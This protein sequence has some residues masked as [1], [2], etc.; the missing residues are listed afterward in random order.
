MCIKK[1]STLCIT[2]L[3]FYH[4]LWSQ[5]ITSLKKNVWKLPKDS[6]V[7]TLNK[8]K[9]IT[10]DLEVFSIK[11][12]W[13]ELLEEAGKKGN[14]LLKIEIYKV[15]EETLNHGKH[16]NDM[17]RVSGERLVYAE[18]MGLLDEAGLANLKL[19]GQYRWLNKSDKALSFLLKAK[20][21]F[22]KTDN[23]ENLYRVYSELGSFYC[24]I[25]PAKAREYINKALAII[26][27]TTISRA[28]S[29]SVI[30]NINTKALTY[31]AEN[32]E[33]EALK[34][35]EEAL[36]FAIT[37]KDS[38]WEGIISGNMAMI[39]MKQKDYDKALAFM[40]KDL[41]LSR[42]E[43]NS[44]NTHDAIGE[45]YI[46]KGEYDI[47]LKHLDSA[48]YLA[49]KL[50]SIKVLYGVHNGYHK[51][52]KKLNNIDKAYFHLGEMFA[53]RDS[54]YKQNQNAKIKQIQ[55]QY[56]FDKQEEEISSLKE[57]SNLQNQ[58][59]Q[60]QKVINTGILVLILVLVVFS[61][62]IYLN[63]LKTKTLNQAL[64]TQKE[65]ILTQNEELRQNQEELA[66]QRD[67]IIEAS[68]E[69][70]NTNN[71]LETANQILAYRET[72]VRKSIE[73]ALSIQQVILPYQ[74]EMDKLLK[75]YFV[76][77][78]PKDVVSG[79]FYWLNQI[80]AQTI[81][82]VADCTGHGV[83]GAFMTLIGANLLD[84]I[85]RL[86]QNLDPA[87]IL[88]ELHNEIQIFLKQKYTNNLNGMDAIVVSF[89][90]NQEETQLTFA[91]AKNN[92]LYFD[93]GDNMLKCLKA[94]RKGIGGY[95]N[96]NTI[97]EN[98]SI[99]LKKGSILYIGSDGLID[100]NNKKRVRLGN[101]K[102][103]E[104]ILDNIDKTMAQQK[105]ALET[106]LVDYIEGTEQ[107]DDILYMGIR[108]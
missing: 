31:Q 36:E 63:S 4:F 87:S 106:L 56:D 46:L 74:E 44:A 50:K 16:H 2:F 28:D 38:E 14:P 77:Y 90:S 15:Y 19:A 45:I 43:A 26:K 23:K 88:E 100:Q 99:S 49:T 66:T 41:Y 62:F 9:R 72:Q 78:R 79:D 21:N 32:K 92:L 65:E 81:L 6:L 76:M 5:D 94:T 37:Y 10:Q 96:E 91:G 59:L 73:A 52:Y 103:Q 3:F 67:Y 12:H 68:K 97:F 35:Y 34:Q 75:D 25:E 1:I 80:G 70:T 71:E 27:K 30:S 57:K 61:Y 18:K 17:L 93:K 53:L 13:Q 11:K 60:Q 20:D 29:R 108:L 47:A 8:I 86:R 22:K 54:T 48:F 7:S 33:K 107:R 51:T 39:Y 42:S 89:V 102:V 105:Q 83:Q 95:Q 69:L 104:V 24:F 101:K 64:Y 40:K 98:Q 58:N 82:V 84:K 85:I 55:S